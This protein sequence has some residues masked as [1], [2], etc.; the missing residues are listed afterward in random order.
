MN[1]PNCKNHIHFKGIKKCN[2]CNKEF[3]LC[4]LTLACIQK[5]KCLKCKACESIFSDQAITVGD[6]CPNCKLDNLVN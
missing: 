6:Q 2:K 3:S 1:C 5:E 4:Q